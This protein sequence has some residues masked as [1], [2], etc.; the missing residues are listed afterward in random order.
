MC[1][2]AEIFFNPNVKK[3]ASVLLRLMM[4]AVKETLCTH[5]VKRERERVKEFGIQEMMGKT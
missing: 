3:R 4:C 1:V 5:K 2:E